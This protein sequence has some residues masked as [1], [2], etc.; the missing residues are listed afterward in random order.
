MV[1]MILFD[2]INTVLQSSLVVLDLNMSALEENI[3]VTN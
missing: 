3:T 2:G 1:M